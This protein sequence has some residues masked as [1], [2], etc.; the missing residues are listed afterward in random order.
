MSSIE[1]QD[2]DNLIEKI[3]NHAKES[4]SEAVRMDRIEAKLD[5]LA[6]AVISIARA[7]EKIAVLMD[8]TKEIKESIIHNGKKIQELEIMTSSN[9]SGIQA[10]SKFFWILTTAIVSIAVVAIAVSLGIPGA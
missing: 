1:K 4:R 5:Q 2:F 6:D 10:V 8:D 7:E 9:T 3:D